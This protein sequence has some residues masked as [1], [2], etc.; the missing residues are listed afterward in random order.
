[1]VEDVKTLAAWDTTK[2]RAQEFVQLAAKE[3]WDEAT[4]KFNGLYGAQATSRSERP[5]RVRISESVRPATTAGRAIGI[6]RDPA[7]QHPWVS[8]PA[9]PVE[10]PRPVSLTDSSPRPRPIRRPSAQSPKVMEFKPQRTF[11]C[12][13]SITLNPLN[14]QQFKDMKGQMLARQS[15]IEAQSLA[16]VHLNPKKHRGTYGLPMVS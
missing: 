12:I 2:T 8:G 10:G 3:G 14:Q 11:Y 16:A 6:D 9:S 1:M 5:E 15:H 13:K 4:K 7:R